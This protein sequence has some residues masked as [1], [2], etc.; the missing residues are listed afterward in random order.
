MWKRLTQATGAGWLTLGALFLF[1]DA[2][3]L[4]HREFSLGWSYYITLWGYLGLCVLAGSLLLTGHIIGKWFVTALAV[5]LAIY[6]A[7]LWGAADGAPFW[8]QLW[9]GTMIAFAGWSIC[10]VQRRNA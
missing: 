2:I 3:E 6:A 4:P 1:W 9:C 8:A 10:L 5:L 7:L